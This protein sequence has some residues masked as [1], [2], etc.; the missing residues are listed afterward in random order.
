MRKNAYIYVYVLLVVV[1]STDHQDTFPGDNFPRPR[2]STQARGHAAKMRQRHYASDRA[3]AMSLTRG[4]TDTSTN[5]DAMTNVPM[6]APA[7]EAPFVTTTKEVPLMSTTPTNTSSDGVSEYVPDAASEF[8]AELNA[9]G[10]KHSG[11]QATAGSDDHHDHDDDAT[12]EEVAM[13]D[14]AKTVSMTQTQTHVSFHAMI[15]ARKGTLVSQIDAPEARSHDDEGH[16][17]A[18]AAEALLM[19]YAHHCTPDQISQLQSALESVK[20]EIIE[21]SSVGETQLQNAG[22]TDATPEYTF[23]VPSASFEENAEAKETAIAHVSAPNGAAVAAGPA[24]EGPVAPSGSDEGDTTSAHPPIASIR[25]KLSDA[26]EFIVDEVASLVGHHQLPQLPRIPFRNVKSPLALAPVAASHLIKFKDEILHATDKARRVLQGSDEDDTT[27]ALDDSDSDEG[28]TSSGVDDMTANDAYSRAIVAVGPARIASIRKKFSDAGEVIVDEVASLVGHH[29]LPQLPRIPFRNV[30]SP[31]TQAKVAASH[32]IKFKD[33]ILH[34]TDKARRVLQGPSFFRPRRRD[35]D[36]DDDDD[37]D[38]DDNE[39]R[40]DD[41]PIGLTET[42]QI[43]RGRSTYR[44]LVYLPSTYNS[45]L[46]YPLLM[47][48]HGLGGEYVVSYLFDHELEPVVSCICIN[49]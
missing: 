49:H 47:S 7:M 19:Q 8:K 20:N 12:R 9:I 30:K 18:E 23:V 21:K 45:S 32:L 31:L 13:A 39:D 11:D 22:G 1:M 3:K 10:M 43:S 28:D 5:M 37:T 38:T 48:N 6:D 2:L 46:S 34:A 44:T 33:E 26:G 40:D 36:D 27:S 25:R 29:Q 15:E 17:S 14:S 41:E 24:E 42:Y 4:W 35:D 16:I